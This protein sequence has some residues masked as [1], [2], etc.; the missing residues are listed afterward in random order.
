MKYEVARR[1]RDK[2]TGKL[3]LPGDS[4]ICD[5]NERLENLLTRGLIKKSYESL[6]KKDLSERLKEK[7][8]EH[9]DKQTKAELIALLGGD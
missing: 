9:S 3:I 2:Y 4:F 8:I 5:E 1:F 7:G 6:S